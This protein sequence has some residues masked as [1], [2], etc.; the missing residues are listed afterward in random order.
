MQPSVE[1]RWQDAVRDGARVPQLELRAA[2]GALLGRD[3]EGRV[4]L[5]AL[6]RRRVIGRSQG[7]NIQVQCEDR[8][9]VQ[10][11]RRTGGQ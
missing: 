4:D 5:P 10:Q 7:R 6:E 9:R 3:G 11:Q 1:L 8:S 2:G